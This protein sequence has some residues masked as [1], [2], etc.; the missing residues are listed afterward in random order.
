MLSTLVSVPH[1]N[2]YKD[3]SIVLEYGSSIT[4]ISTAVFII[5]KLNL[6]FEIYNTH[7]F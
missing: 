3:F 1:S 4:I 6:Y 7:M 5:T 2:Y